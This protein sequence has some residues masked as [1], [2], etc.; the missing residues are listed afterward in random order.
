M[1]FGTMTRPKPH[2]TIATHTLPLLLV[3]TSTMV[4]ATHD[5]QCKGTTLTSRR[6]FSIQF[7]GYVIL[8]GC[9]T[10]FR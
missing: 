2:H 4:N 10:V 8:S 1:V 3:I 5:S 6:L 9:E 7:G